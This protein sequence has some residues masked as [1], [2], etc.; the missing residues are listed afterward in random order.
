[1]HINAVGTPVLREILGHELEETLVLFTYDSSAVMPGVGVV[2][3]LRIW[4]VTKEATQLYFPSGGFFS[5]RL[6]QP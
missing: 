4:Q 6:I 2:S 3:A 1:M 5:H